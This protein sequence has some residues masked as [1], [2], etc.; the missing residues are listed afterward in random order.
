[1]GP[2]ITEKYEILLDGGKFGILDLKWHRWDIFVASGP[3]G[4]E[5]LNAWFIDYELPIYKQLYIGAR[6]V[7]YDRKAT[8]DDFDDITKQQ[9]EIRT[10]VTLHF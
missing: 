4:R 10:F 7:Y 1:M 2:G 9:N 3:A 8:Y 5:T 6:Y